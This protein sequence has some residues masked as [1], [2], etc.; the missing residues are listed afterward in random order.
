MNRTELDVTP[1]IAQAAAIVLLGLAAAFAG[2]C[3]KDGACGDGSVF[4]CGGATGGGDGGEGPDAKTGG[5]PT[6]TVGAGGGS[7][8]ANP[9]GVPGCEGVAWRNP[10]PGRV[11]CVGADS[12]GCDLPTTCC[13]TTMDV[14]DHVFEATCG[15]PEQCVGALWTCDG[16]EDCGP[17][18]VCCLD[19]GGTSCVAAEDCDLTKEW[20]CRE[21]ADCDPGGVVQDECEA[22]DGDIVGFCR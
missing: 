16:P 3:G 22:G 4:G 9:L 6:S 19:D 15:A 5:M 17:G 10:T 18:T 2:A 7:M 8:A 11:L 20:L 12:C 13:V 1:R 21:D 14:G